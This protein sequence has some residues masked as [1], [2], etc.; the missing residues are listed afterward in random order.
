MTGRNRVHLLF[1][2]LHKWLAIG[3]GLQVLIWFGSGAFMSFVPIETVRGEHLVNRNQEVPLPG[4]ID[5]TNIAQHVSSGPSGVLSVQI[6]E[7]DGA[8]VALIKS[9]KTGIIRIDLKSGAILPVL[10]AQAVQRI[11]KA[12]WLGDPKIGTSATWI[13]KEPGDYRGDVPVWQVRFDDPDAT[14]VYIEPGTGRILAVRTRT[15]RVYDF[16]WGLHIM[17][18]K[19]RENINTPWLFAFALSGV[20]FALAGAVLLFLRWPR[21]KRRKA[22]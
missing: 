18:W 2:R 21:R 6:L 17:D 14:S 12:S 3:I 19:A 4:N 20:A 22:H 11:A 7:V 13:V 15:W 16:L 8:P 10:D 5:L 1:S 9:K